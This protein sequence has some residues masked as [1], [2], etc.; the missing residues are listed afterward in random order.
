MTSDGFIRNTLSGKCID[1]R[2]SPAVDSGAP[3]QL[4]DCDFGWPSAQTDQKVGI[5]SRWIH[6]ESVIRQVHRC[7]EY[8]GLAG[9]SRLCTGP[10]GSRQWSV[11]AG[12]LGLR[13][14]GTFRNRSEVGMEVISHCARRGERL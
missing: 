5:D 3:L 2:G 8:T 1:A 7:N 11:T 13:I 14:L 9:E 4:W 6:Q 12:L 10:A